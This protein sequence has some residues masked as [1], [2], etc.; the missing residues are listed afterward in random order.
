[1]IRV[2]VLAGLLSVSLLSGCFQLRALL[3]LADDGSAVL[4]ETVLVSGML[5]EMLAADSSRASELYVLD[6]L[7]AN[8]SRLGEGVTLLRV[9]TVSTADGDGYRAVYAVEDVR[10]LRFRFNPRPMPG[11]EQSGPRASASFLAGTSDDLA[12]TFERD[13]DGVLRVSLPRRGNEAGEPAE[14]S[15]AAVTALADTLRRQT[16]TSGVELAAALEGVRFSLEL[17][18]PGTVAETDARFR[19]DSSVVLFDYSLG[20]FFGLARDKPELVARAQLL[21]RAGT[22]DHTAVLAALAAQP[23][24]RYEMRPQVTVRYA[25]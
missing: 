13:A 6:S 18:G 12:V 5:R 25:R 16:Q 15:R 7:R 24:V 8:A 21:E 20:A 22:P 9:D 10:S 14:P 23:G 1:M 3:R 4:E 11:A 2:R 17:F 19:S